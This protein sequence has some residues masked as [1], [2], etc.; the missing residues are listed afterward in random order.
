MARTG[1]TCRPAGYRP[2][3]ISIC[4][5]GLYLD[6]LTASEGAAILNEEVGLQAPPVAPWPVF[7]AVR[8][9]IRTLGIVGERHAEAVC[10]RCRGPATPGQQPGSVRRDAEPD[11]GHQAPELLG[12]GPR[13]LPCHRTA[14]EVIERCRPGAPRIRASYPA[15]RVCT[16]RV[17]ALYECLHCASACTAQV[18]AP[19]PSQPPLCCRGPLVSAE[20]CV[21]A[22]PTAVSWKE[23]TRE[24][25]GRKATPARAASGRPAW[26]PGSHDAPAGERG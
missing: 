10:P 21:A 15:M 19:C 11:C 13:R 7:G 14:L 24:Q 9:G 12:P 17:P 20:H 1:R 3:Y 6:T 23:R 8:C 25:T 26:P 18:P 2:R 4:I 22:I 5:H 16:V